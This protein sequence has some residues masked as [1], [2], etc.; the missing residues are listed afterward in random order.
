MTEQRDYIG[1]DWVI[2][3][4]EKTLTDAR[5]HLERYAESPADEGHLNQCRGQLQQIHST[6]K[7]LRQKGARLLTGEMLV[8]LDNLLTQH[9]SGQSMDQLQDHLVML[10][11]GMLQLPGYLAHTSRSGTDNPALLKTLLRE[12]RALRGKHALTDMDFF[13]PNI[14]NPIAAIPPEQL[15]KLKNS[16][17]APLVRKIRQKYQLCLAGVLRDSNR[18][19]QL[20]VIGKIFAKLQNLCW[21]SPISPLWDAA[22]ALSEG[23]REGSIPVDSHAI[24]LLR[25]MDHQLKQLA[26]K[27]V[28]GL[29]D[30]PQED[31]LREI[32]Y[33]IAKASSDNNLIVAL[34]HRYSLDKALVPPPASTGNLLS[35]DAAAPVVQAIKEELSA[36]K[37]TLDLYLLNPESNQARLQEQLPVCQK[38]ADTLSML[39]QNN[40]RS[41]MLAQQQALQ[42]I[43][44]NP[45]E[46]DE[47]GNQLID[48]AAKILDIQAGLNQY[49]GL[50]RP[51]VKDQV[52]SPQM[53][54]IHQTVI[55][56]ARQNLEQAK[57]S[58]MDYL[59]NA[60]NQEFLA[61][62]PPLMQT[63]QGGL[64]I[65]P[66]TRVAELVSQCARHVQNQWLGKNTKPS[67]EELEAL[68]D[69][70]A[71]IEFYLEQLSSGASAETEKVLDITQQSLE[72]LQ[73]GQPV[74]VPPSV[75]QTT[76][77]AEPLF[78]LERDGKP[79]PDPDSNTLE[80][81]YESPETR[82]QGEE[83]PESE[84]TDYG[85]TIE[86][87]PVTLPEGARTRKAESD[88]DSAEEPRLKEEVQP[89][90]P[91][92]EPVLLEDQLIPEVPTSVAVEPVIEADVEPAPE[93]AQ[94]V[95]ISPI[96]VHETEEDE[97]L[98]AIFAEEAADVQD[99]LESSFTLLRQDTA[100][101]IY[102][103]NVR[104]AFHTLKGS[105]RMI[106]AD[107]IGELAWSIENMLNQAIDGS[108]N[109]SDPVMDLLAES[110]E[111]MPELVNDF[112][113]DS[114]QLTPE[115][116]LCMEKADAL[117]K[118]IS[119]VA[120]VPEEQVNSAAEEPAMLF[121]QVAGS[122]ER[123]EEPVA[124]PSEDAPRQA[125]KT[126]SASLVEEPPEEPGIDTQLLEV[127]ESEAKEHLS[128]V[129]AFIE[130]SYCL[131]SNLQI[132][133]QVQRAL[134][135][136]K[137]SAYM[138]E[139]TPLADWIA[140]IEKTVKAFRTHLIPADNQVI[141]MLE[142]SVDL[143]EKA[144]VQ[145]KTPPHIISLKVDSFLNW[146]KAL[147][148][149][150][151]SRILTEE[152]TQEQQ[153]VG[154]QAALFLASDLDLLL[155]AVSY[156]EKW[157]DAIPVEELDRFKFE[158][159]VLAE[160]ATEAQLHPM[161]E[162]CDVL[163]DVCV[164]LDK[165]A[166]VLPEALA[167]PF[168]EGFKAL[169]E[170]MNQVASQQTPESPQKVFSALR[171]AL[172]TLLQDERLQD[173]PSAEQDS[174]F[175]EEIILESDHSEPEMILEAGDEQAFEEEEIIL[176]SSTQP[177]SV[178]SLA[179]EEPA[180]QPEPAIP[181]PSILVEEHLDQDLL[182]LFLEEAFDLVEDSAQALENWL[183][184]PANLDPV[185]E[186]QRHLHTLK[187]GAMMT[188]LH[189]LGQ[190]SHAL[191]DVYE[192]ITTHR[193][194]PDD[195]PL[196]LIQ[197]TH[198]T[199]ESALKALSTDQ[200]VPD[201]SVMLEELKNWQGRLAG[202]ASTPPTASL[203]E[204]QVDTLP[205]YLGKATPEGQ[206]APVTG[207]TAK[208]EKTGGKASS[209]KVFPEWL[210][211]RSIKP[212]SSRKLSSGTLTSAV[213]PK[214]SPALK[215]ST[216]GQS[217]AQ[218]QNSEMVRVPS[219]LLEN[220][221]NLAG[222]ASI[223][224]SRIEQHT[225]DAVKTLDEMNT[226]IIRVKEQL[227]RL[228]IETQTQILSRH[229][230]D[231]GENP[232]FDPLEMDQYSE[233]TQ[234]SHS[235]VESASDLMD[236][237]EALQEKSRD[238]ESLL[239]Q[240]SRTQIELQEQLMK[241]RMVSFSRLVPRL[242]KIVRQVS[243]DLDKPVE[244][245]V[246]NAEGEMD[247]TMLERILAPL[248]H[249]L[250]NAISHGIEDSA[251]ERLK[252]GKPG[253]GQ[254][255]LS[256]SR[257][258]ADVLVDLSDDGRGINTEAVKAK[259]LEQN[260]ISPDNQI[261]DQDA[262][263]LIMESGFSTAD[264]VSH[265]SGRGVGL[266]VVNSEV[267]QL[268][269]S[270]QIHS[271]A[272]KGTRFS[273]RL[274][275]TLSI[276]RA[277]MVEVGS[278]LYALP[279]HAIDGIS[280]I[281]ASLLKDCYESGSPLVYGN[282]TEHQVIYMGQLVNSGTPRFADEQCPVVLVQRG[283][284]NLAVQV[285]SII[286]SREIITKSLGIQFA[287]LAGVNGATILGDGRVVVIIDPAALY[288]KYQ[289]STPDSTEK[290]ELDAI[291][292]ATR[293]LV[294]DDSVTVRKVTSR[295]LVRQ[296]YE[297]SAARDG[298]EAMNQ[299]SEQRPDII[300][301]DIEMPKMDGFEVASAIRNDPE[302]KDLPII[303]ITS[304][305]GEKH[306]NRAFGLGVNE[307]IGKPFQ[308]GLLLETIEKLITVEQP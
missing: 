143:I 93:A 81:H 246:T 26:E 216:A 65:I 128:V 98:H 97:D 296:G 10:M 106:G 3:E 300:L 236:L 201:F 265:I 181:E 85:S 170:M 105:G 208:G 177:V 259:A 94:N 249:M 184:A 230:G 108:I 226:T 115:V 176:E 56:E 225:A 113:R 41:I 13:T 66:L 267:H 152:E 287:G 145:L 60:H 123:P 187:G 38:I 50:S 294:V 220:L 146:L 307:Y 4:I 64:A 278:S 245:V 92:F 306:R 39:G 180:T 250:R 122:Q 282:G 256:I 264:H 244:L 110:I 183:K 87:V 229:Q 248:E 257:D 120:E 232:N 141:S 209:K 70:L 69:T 182:H 205:D 228:D 29:N 241:A 134:H 132:S 107:V 83:K 16:G 118:G 194:P 78:V 178:E 21:G 99:Q 77:D 188:D 48:V 297:V 195:A 35:Y 124:A 284:E 302:L 199:I 9:K 42:G 253:Q 200:P 43:L 239:L 260:L 289:I 276:N 198:D 74:L 270:I 214:A 255:E 281:S 73:Q 190:L 298:V 273:L 139:I 133:D 191:E 274:P 258:G 14:A 285:D 233:L 52:I 49:M 286:G 140:A 58:V 89:E 19:N 293:V 17:F 219:D 161:A 129:K 173:S 111:I 47:I 136:L 263:G 121:G 135:T 243:S 125:E 28:N 212:L 126:S 45:R 304:R 82:S 227:R 193:C 162:L 138:A 158:L 102:L 2:G 213:P 169:V 240:Q 44:H 1:L 101:L 114:Q 119:F 192:S 96:T 206:K 151:L 112:A 179:P 88:T 8:L 72:K 130:S 261:S 299:L 109:L 104:R 174:D 117:G 189:E 251:K 277:L 186:L 137:G 15:G 23:L 91:L 204:P 75:S 234:L 303:M 280:M 275:F 37:D 63:I 147:H 149:E 168:T 222:E 76:E 86:Y 32:L 57:G 292:Q 153:P 171:E 223:N 80:F 71:S 167:T 203:E 235:L 164:Y 252:L 131:G 62:L 127:F 68:A 90:K 155:D 150:L 217:G 211:S 305:T 33:R 221:I 271:E 242:R 210:P 53:S 237:R 202:K 30:L 196:A 103:N 175:E 156:L 224:R 262:I 160:N 288:R 36:I 84:S 154:Q 24:T 95:A 163:L 7:V 308:E 148:D 79:E 116:L 40:L 291:E 172:E 301:L 166:T 6:L 22:T 283:S 165:H 31:L 18:D 266:D 12:M 268:G 61:K 247:R 295:L 269:G 11:Q 290:V 46:G 142:Q 218:H 20:V 34:K 5:Q 207:D 159:R 51:V 144:L 185:N 55:H 279:M 100:N 215:A 59:G 25:E 54:D 231:L 157:A 27:G 197:K 67:L 254:I 272:D 238:T